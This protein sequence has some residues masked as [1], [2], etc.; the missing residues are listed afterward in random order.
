MI[1]DSGYKC[2]KCNKVYHRTDWNLPKYCRGCGADL[3]EKR[4]LYN[5][6]MDYDGKVYETTDDNMWGGYDYRK[7]ILTKNIE[8]TKLR[9]HLFKWKIFE[10]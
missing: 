2:K 3:V 10:E 9:W 1:V 8:K 7:V 4:Y 5:L 6:R